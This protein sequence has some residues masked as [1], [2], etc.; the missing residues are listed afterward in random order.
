[1]Q[2]KQAYNQKKKKTN[3]KVKQ[4]FPQETKCSNAY[5][6]ELSNHLVILCT[7]KI[8]VIFNFFLYS[9]QVLCTWFSKYM[10]KIKQKLFCKCDMQYRKTFRFDDKY[11]FDYNSQAT[12][13]CK[14]IG[15]FLSFLTHSRSSPITDE[16]QC[17][18]QSIPFPLF[19]CCSYS[20]QKQQHY[21]QQWPGEGEG[22]EK[23]WNVDLEPLK[24]KVPNL[25]CKWVYVVVVIHEI[26]RFHSIPQGRHPYSSNLIETHLW[27]PF[28]ISLM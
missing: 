15:T 9:Y 1:M 16:F 2:N 5:D 3:K 12:L 23:T 24:N 17:L 14:I 26:R 18:F 19:Q 10:T 21:M 13:I 28:T 25:F 4:T 7:C 22:S 27:K 11:D 8:F 20:Y 6:Y